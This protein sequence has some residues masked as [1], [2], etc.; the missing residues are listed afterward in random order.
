MVCGNLLMMGLA[1]AVAVAQRWQL[2]TLRREISEMQSQLHI[3]RYN[4]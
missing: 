2:S 3:G 1:V 4:Y